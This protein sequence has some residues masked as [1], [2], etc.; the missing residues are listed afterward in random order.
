[1]DLKDKKIIYELELN[2][3]ISS[4]KLGKKIG[5]SKETTNNRIKILE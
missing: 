5:L 4:S 3:R 1:M 2:G